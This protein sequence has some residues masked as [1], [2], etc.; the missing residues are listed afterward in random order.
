MPTLNND[1][2]RKE[3]YA[4]V[5]YEHEWKNSLKTNQTYHGINI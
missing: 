3:W 1:S 4:I 5:A 2:A